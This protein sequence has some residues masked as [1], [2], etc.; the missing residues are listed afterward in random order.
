MPPTMPVRIRIISSPP[1]P[2]NEF[3]EFSRR[4]K[5]NMKLMSTYFTAYVAEFEK[6]EGGCPGCQMARDG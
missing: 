4:S 5:F 6:V 3:R 1:R 2:E